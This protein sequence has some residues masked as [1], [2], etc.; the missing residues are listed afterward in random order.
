MKAVRKAETF[1]NPEWFRNTAKLAMKRGT[2]I[3]FSP[4]RVVYGIVPK[5]GGS[6]NVYYKADE[7]WLDAVLGKFPMGA[8]FPAGDMYGGS[9]VAKMLRPYANIR[10]PDDGSGRAWID[11]ATFALH[12]KGAGLQIHSSTF[13]HCDSPVALPPAKFD[14]FDMEEHIPQDIGKLLVEFTRRD[15]NRPY[16]RRVYGIEKEGA[17]M[18]GATSGTSAMTIECPSLPDDFS[19][20]P[21]LTP[22]YDITGFCRTKTESGAAT[23]H[24]LMKD[25]T[26]VSETSPSAETPP[27]VR[28]LNAA[29]EGDKRQIIGQ[30]A[31]RTLDEQ[32]TELGLGSNDVNG[33]AL[34]LKNGRVSMTS[35]GEPVAEFDTD[36]RIEGEPILVAYPL[37]SRIAK[38]CGDFCVSVGVTKDGSERVM[39]YSKTDTAFAVGMPLALAK[40]T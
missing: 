29:D 10:L 30:L 11:A 28:V 20:D 38:L 21:S 7:E 17:V 18:L 2:S 35:R 34:S 36:C 37:L 24:Y 6:V 25:G 1:L 27:I 16:L 4:K 31:L 3:I 9:A 40:P 23:N 13:S 19:C 5:S 8:I 33:G 22:L 14:S 15:D 39:L 32:I 12:V 26:I